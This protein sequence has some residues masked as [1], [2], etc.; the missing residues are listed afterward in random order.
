MT[1]EAERFNLAHDRGDFT[2]LCGDAGRL[3]LLPIIF[4]TWARLPVADRRALRG[5]STLALVTGAGA[6]VGLPADTYPYGRPHIR[7]GAELP[8]AELPSALAHE[9][10]HVFLDHLAADA[11]ERP[12][13]VRYPPGV[14]SAEVIA[15]ALATGEYIARPLTDAEIA[16]ERAAWAQVAKWGFPVPDAW[17]E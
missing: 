11:A 1:T 15:A 16:R 9:W 13:R 10:A 17:R 14:L 5:R 8:L 7:I 3:D 4:D 2:Q 12:A 6:S